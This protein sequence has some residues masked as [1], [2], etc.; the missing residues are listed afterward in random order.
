MKVHD[1]APDPDPDPT[2]PSPTSPRTRSRS[3]S[4]SRMSTRSRASSVSAGTTNDTPNESA[5]QPQPRPE[6]ISRLLSSSAKLPLPPAG[7]SS[8]PSLSE[9][10]PSA[11]SSSRASKHSSI[12]SK[13]N[14]LSPSS[15]PRNVARTSSAGKK[16]PPNIAGPSS[17]PLPRY[18]SDSFIVGGGTGG[19][20]GSTASGAS[21]TNG[22]NEDK[23]PLWAMGG[24]FP[25]K[26]RRRSSAAKDWAKSREKE[27]K[28]L[29]REREKNRKL[30]SPPRA[31]RMESA[32]TE[33]SST[34]EEEGEYTNRERGD[35]GLPSDTIVEQ[36]DPFDRVSR[37]GG[38]SDGSEKTRSDM[39]R[40]GSTRS[41]PV[42]RQ[43]HGRTEEEDQNRNQDE[44]RE[45][46]LERKVSPGSS[47]LAEEAEEEEEANRQHE[48]E[49]D[50]RMEK[51][52]DEIE[53]DS[54]RSR[55]R[56]SYADYL[57][58]H[59][60]EDHD[61]QSEDSQSTS[62]ASSNSAQVGGQLNQKPED[63]REEFN[64]DGGPPIRNLW[65]T[66]RYALREPMAEFLGTMILVVLGVGADC[67]TKISAESS[68][69]T[70]FV[71]G[72][73]VMISVYIA[74][75]ISGGHTNPAVTISLAL[76][77]GF[78]WKM[79][80]RYILAQVL[81]AFVGALMIY[82]NYKRAINSYD[83]NKLIHASV[84]PPLN[85]S[86]T[87]F[88][89]A[90][91]PQVGTTPLGFAQEI[92]A[93]GILMIAVLALGDENNAPPG[94]GL[95]AIVLG[96]VVV[97]IGMSNGWVSGY[98]INPAR[99]IGPRFALWAVG[100]GTQVWTHDDC[101]WIF[102]PLL[103]PLVGSVGGC[104]AYD[105]LI[106]NGP[107]SP[108]NWSLHELAASIGLPQ[109]YH[110]AKRAT[111]PHFRH[112]EA[113]VERDLEATLPPKSSMIRRA[114]LTGRDRPGRR[115]STER[116]DL[117]VVQRW[118]M[119]R[120]RVEKEQENN[121]DKYEAARRRKADR[122]RQQVKEK[123]DAIED[124][125]AAEIM[126]GEAMDTFTVRE[127]G[128]REESPQ[129]KQH[130]S[131]IRLRLTVRGGKM[132]KKRAFGFDP[133]QKLEWTAKTEV[134]F[135][136]NLVQ[137]REKVFER[138]RRLSDPALE[139]RSLKKLEHLGE[140][141]QILRSSVQRYQ[142]FCQAV[143][144][145]VFPIT[146]EA[147]A[148]FI[149][150]KC[151]LK[152]GYYSSALAY[153]KRVRNET[154][155]LWEATTA[156][157]EANVE[158]ERALKE[159]MRERESIRIR[160]KGSPRKDHKS[161]KSQ[162][163]LSDASTSEEPYEGSSSDSDSNGK[164]G[165]RSRTPDP[166]ESFEYSSD[167]DSE[168]VSPRSR[169]LRAQVTNSDQREEDNQKDTDFHARVEPTIDAAEVEQFPTPGLPQFGDSFNSAQDLLVV[170][171]HS[172]LPIYGNGVDATSSRFQGKT[173]IQCY[174]HRSRNGSCPW[175][176]EAVRKS[177]S[178]KLVVRE[179]G[180]YLF[181]NH[182]R[183]PNIVHDPQ[184]R[185][186]IRNEVRANESPISNSQFLSDYS[187][188]KKPKISDLSS[189]ESAPRPPTVHLSPARYTPS[190]S[191][192]TLEQ[193]KGCSPWDVGAV[194]KSST[195]GFIVDQA[196]SHLIHSQD[197][198][199]GIARDPT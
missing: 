123:S 194:V 13:K 36:N 85:A 50:D 96:F 154:S 94:A 39:S 67:Q 168:A 86:A 106:F 177:S 52:R 158:T 112:P 48:R 105:M 166:D 27:R 74:G 147:I 135:I 141:D 7:S 108:V 65:G 148:L 130:T 43:D 145:P 40:G 170:C 18:E 175:R 178:N 149:F 118:R 198:A 137:E 171:Y 189:T 68:T 160:G 16:H 88:F 173:I 150:A 110:M 80:P 176:L 117:E 172:M 184:W 195:G 182:G 70:Y 129:R 107:G 164:L 188:R 71:W 187:P 21:Q 41:R 20:G 34:V 77:R 79:V 89:T 6:P 116:K 99:D 109:M 37:G 90:P 113:K 122:I 22:T 23:P 62:A 114:E 163:S 28:E 81:G 98:A 82:G 165:P 31:E 45:T 196:S 58:Q 9:R 131:V 127:E 100:Y 60:D 143:N 93:G 125:F 64:D 69:N 199:K 76:F 10:T 14:Q 140:D 119:G 193:R 138:I 155:Y 146:I 24:V 25:K 180:S 159:F 136:D 57:A 30:K 101:W 51:G 124:A 104:L 72:F 4:S 19:G 87:L 133:L 63:W 26:D 33:H 111:H 157:T 73:A 29:Q 191:R 38:A 192:T 179:Q 75:G 35:G 3:Q 185:P 132:N 183:H 152:N 103:G 12:F 91:A 181:H 167:S 49:Y 169:I 142:E 54:Q 84:D 2:T 120:E 56:D 17:R 32:I 66:V 139:A 78:P 126:N 102:G 162:A 95:G 47:T 1:F 153:V 61:D 161:K 190:S 121:R 197:C 115:G 59:R 144:I 174:R 5:S 92:L 8:R 11:V 42:K 186:R 55:D 15:R 128:E 134:E 46:P 97:A 156:A 151:S 83:P 44:I 53:R